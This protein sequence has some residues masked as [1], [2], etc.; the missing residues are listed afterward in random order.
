[1]ITNETPGQLVKQQL[2]LPDLALLDGR[3][4]RHDKSVADIEIELVS[5]L[6]EACE[7]SRVHRPFAGER[8]PESTTKSSRWAPRP[9]I[10]TYRNSSARHT[11]YTPA[12]RRGTWSLGQSANLNSGPAASSCTMLTVPAAMPQFRSFIATEALPFRP[13]LEPTPRTSTAH[14][15]FAACGPVLTFRLISR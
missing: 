9:L 3:E 4:N 7:L 10:P 15:E 13:S 11:V 5:R 12:E 2:P 8:W 6:P 14:H 1:V